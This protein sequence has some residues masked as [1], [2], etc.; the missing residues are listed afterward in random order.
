MA[1]EFSGLEAMGSFG[2]ATRE[3]N[4]YPARRR[5]T[6]KLHNRGRVVTVKRETCSQRM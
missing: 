1:K 2:S 4:V 6:W 3:A 5:F